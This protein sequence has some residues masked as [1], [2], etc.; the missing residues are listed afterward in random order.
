MGTTVTH[1]SGYIV[2][3]LPWRMRSLQ[4]KAQSCQHHSADGSS[5]GANG[6]AE[7]CEHHLCQHGASHPHTPG[8]LPHPRDDRY[9]L[10]YFMGARTGAPRAKFFED[11]SRGLVIWIYRLIRLQ[12]QF[13]PA[14][15]M[16]YSAGNTS[17]YFRN[18]SPLKY[19][20]LLSCRRLRRQ[21]LVSGVQHI[22]AK[23]QLCSVTALSAG[24][25]QEKQERDF[26]N[27]ELQ[28]T[29]LF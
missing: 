19:P 3:V 7:M 6:N 21:S 4:A 11:G 29:F 5:I 10:S 25:L 8:R 23:D 24:A 17:A 22:T 12:A 20:F 18:P 13:F 27:H 26:T 2:R 1:L 14:T 28:G 16:S 9:R 15:T